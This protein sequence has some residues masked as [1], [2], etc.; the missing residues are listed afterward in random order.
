MGGK[1][2]EKLWKRMSLAV[3]LLF[4]LMIFA[5][6]PALAED[7]PAPGTPTLIQDADGNYTVSSVEDLNKLRGDID[8]GIDYSSQHVVLTQDIDAGS[9]LNSF[10]TKKEFNGIFNGRFHTINNYTDAVSGLFV[11]VG[12]S[13]VVENVEVDADVVISNTSWS[14]NKDLTDGYYGVISNEAAGTI[15]RCAVT[16]NIKNTAEWGM[17]GAPKIAGIVGN[18]SISYSGTITNM[19]GEINNC[20]SN[21]IF[22]NQSQ[23]SGGLP[24][25]AGIVYDAG[26]GVQPYGSAKIEHSYFNGSFTGNEQE[27]APVIGTFISSI[28]STC[29]YDKD[30]LGDSNVSIY[31]DPVGYTTEEMKKKESYTALGF[32]FDKTWK[33]DPSVN[34]GY[35]YLNPDNMDKVADKIVVDVQATAQDKTYDPDLSESDNRKTAVT[36]VKVVPGSGQDLE[37]VNELISQ[38]NVKASYSGDATFNALTIGDV[39]VNIDSSKIN[40]TF[41]KNDDYEF[42]PGNV[43]PVTAKLKDDG[44]AAPTEDEEK[45]Q[46]ENAKKAENI[47]Y[48]K[49]GIGQGEVP[50]FE[51]IGD[52]ASVSGEEGSIELNNYTW[53]V[54]SS[55][56]SGYAGVREGYYDDWIAAVKDELKRMKE[57]DIVIQDVKMTE[58]EKL[59]LAVTA[60]GYD[61]RDITYD[62]ADLIDIILNKNYIK[63]SH[64]YFTPQYAV[65]ALNSYN[66]IDSVPEDE[67]HISKDDLSGWIH[68]WAESAMGK[69]GA[70]GSVIL[71]NSVPDMATMMMQPIALYYDSD[72]KEGDEY[73]D[74]KQGMEHWLDDK[75]PNAQTYKGSFWGGYGIDYNNA[76]TNAQVYITLGMAAEGNGKNKT[77]DGKFNNVNIFDSKYV[78][79]G[80]T[81]IDA[82]L[83]GFNIGEG[84]TKYDSHTYEPTQ[85]CRGLDSLVRAYEG[86][87]S[88]FDCTD[89]TDSTVPVNNAIEALP[90]VDSITSSDKAQVDAA[91][92]SYNALSAA[93]KSS[94]SQDKVDKLTAAEEKVSGNE[95]TQTIKVTNLLP[96]VS[97]KLGEDAKVSV[98]AEN[99]SGG[100]Q[101]ASLITAL[102]DDTGKFITYASGK[103]AI[104][105]GGSSV[106]TSMLKIPAEGIYKLKAFVWDSLEAMNPLSNVIDIPVESGK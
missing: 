84:T 95:D 87:N 90:A 50:S 96:D 44:A 69:T 35:P 52:K 99:L 42:V 94:I 22:D 71:P 79:C 6:Y 51:W 85:I 100:D 32:D 55:A 103:Q 31:G 54:F 106:L 104:K 10:T 68:N 101:D 77:E 65:L 26:L 91:E 27:K 73:Y 63:K 17:Y 88:I 67:N 45:Q 105:A 37:K 23:S 93:K 24:T 58:W 3:V 33:I 21:L 41:D 48:S 38:Y 98:K 92:S 1:E 5:P 30:K 57:A 66:Y 28:A 20:F 86:R 49:L 34:D 47:L 15:M 39:P 8:S 89:V 43:L 72:T 102:Y 76:W 62:G 78:K 11:S 56:R 97:Y 7:A 59:V 9:A 36:D 53:E 14:K 19:N 25:F 82:A 80:S 2:M 18:S 75:F 60:I 29:A 83:E 4:S 70:D 64:M 46:V 61:P 16:G 81:M 13:G 74:V 12:K 40:I